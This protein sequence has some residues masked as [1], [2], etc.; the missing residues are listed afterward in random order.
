MSGYEVETCVNTDDVDELK[1][2]IDEFCIEM[3][4]FYQT[5]N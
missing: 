2:E 1:K 4:I 5:L 3:R